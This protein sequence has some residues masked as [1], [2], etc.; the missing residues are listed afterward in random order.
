MGNMMGED[1]DIGSSNPFGGFNGGAITGG[2]G[3]ENEEW[4]AD[5]DD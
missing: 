3:D 4:E 1:L 5:F 2:G